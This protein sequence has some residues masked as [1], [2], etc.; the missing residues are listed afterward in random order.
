MIYEGTMT[1]DKDRISREKKTISKMIGIYCRHRHG[2]ADDLCAECGHLRD[3]AM[4]CIDR[5]PFREDK[6]VCGKCPVHC[7]EP[8]MRDRI[9]RV[10]RYSGPR[11]MMYHPVLT[12]MHHLDGMK[13]PPRKP[14]GSPK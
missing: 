10:M 3:Y 7:Y 11:M 12:V 1:D 14:G 5:C 2:R 4:Q 13:T 8:D 6:P 9:R